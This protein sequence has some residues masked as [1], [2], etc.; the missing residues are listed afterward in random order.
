MTIVELL[1]VIGIILIMAAIMLPAL[2]MVRE[3]SRETTCRNNLKQ[4]GQAYIR[5]MKFGPDQLDLGGELNWS[6]QLRTYLDGDGDVFHCPHHVGVQTSGTTHS[7]AQVSAITISY[8][9]NNRAN[10]LMSGEKI[11]MLDYQRT[12]INVVGS[13]SAENENWRE[14]Y[15]DWNMLKAPRHRGRL[16]VLYRSGMVDSSAPDDIDPIHCYTYH[17]YWKPARSAVFNRECID[18]AGVVVADY[19]DT[20][21][22]VDDVADET[23]D[24]GEDTDAAEEDTADA[25]KKT[26]DEGL[27]WLI[28]H[29][30]GN[31]GWTLKH[32]MGGRPA[33]AGRCPDESICDKPCTGVA[34]GLALLCFLGN[35]SGPGHGDHKKTVAK[36]INFLIRQVQPNGYIGTCKPRA[37]GY[38]PAFALMALVEAMRSGSIHGSWGSVNPRRLWDASFRALNYVS[39]CEFPTGGFR[40]SCG[41]YPDT[42]V[43]AAMLQSL[44]SS[45][46]ARF[47]IPDLQGI[48]DRLHNWLDLCQNLDSHYPGNVVQDAQFAGTRFYN[49]GIRYGYQP[50]DRHADSLAMWAAGGYMRLYLDPDLKY[51]TAI[52]SLATEFH[53]RLQDA[54]RPDPDR[55]L[56]FYAHHFMRM[57]GDDTGA[58]AVWSDW[59]AAMEQHLIDTRE[60]EGHPR[61]SWYENSQWNPH[62]GRLGVTCL[63]L[64]SL[65]AYYEQIKLTSTN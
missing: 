59:S 12:V 40:Y 5:A 33:C 25:A 28:L 61:G 18:E 37:G 44:K 49:L 47:P 9:I 34:T 24:E 26:V 21:I 45:E 39:H 63:S 38:E 46:E 41:V 22:P 20:E 57:V 53:T 13:K 17:K 19:L 56:N 3:T 51:H 16:N 23:N 54:G 14:K 29:Q 8:G 60:T 6:D 15:D 48:S 58:G 55:Y 30:M 27:I 62:L 1:I 43:T 4:L 50:P 7:D 31:G 36:G 42:S 35:G 64:L 11:V 52:E 2:Q 10:L 65:K 32:H